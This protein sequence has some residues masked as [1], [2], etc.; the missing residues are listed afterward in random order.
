MKIRAARLIYWIISILLISTI[1]LPLS[2]SAIDPEVTITMD[3]YSKKLDV[4]PG[5]DR[6]A[7][8]SGK[9]TLETQGIG[10]N[11]Q[12]VDVELIVS[13]D[14]GW[15][16]S[17]NPSLFH[18]ESPNYYSDYFVLRVTAPE[19]ASAWDLCTVNISGTAT[20][21]PGGVIYYI[22]PVKP[23]IIIEPF[24]RCAVT[25]DKTFTDVSA[26][27]KAEFTIKIENHG[28]YEEKFYLRLSDDI[29]AEV[30]K[31]EIS[32]DNN[33][34]FVDERNDKDTK[35]IVKVPRSADSG[36]HEIIVEIV[37]EGKGDYNIVS[38]DY[39]KVLINVE[40][41]GAFGLGNWSWFIVIVIILIIII[42]AVLKKKGKLSKITTKQ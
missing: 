35:M 33:Y 14:S 41:I 11:V 24:M 31:W 19:E 8:I 17:V 16:A 12:K 25:V 23:T 1:L 7:L 40:K 5:S 15:V 36:A 22:E 28:N 2:A 13:T 30:R 9:I 10:Q 29:D 20:T 37:N 34:L 38:T 27:E 18:F 3:T 4:Q 26:G 32:F 21:I 42:I 39:V 6:T